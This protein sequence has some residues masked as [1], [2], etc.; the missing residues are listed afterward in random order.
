MLLLPRVLLLVAWLLCLSLNGYQRN[1][2]EGQAAKNLRSLL[3]GI[4]ERYLECGWS[5]Q[6]IE[7]GENETHISKRAQSSR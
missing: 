7:M 3:A 1:F 5:W 6:L 4:E 2:E